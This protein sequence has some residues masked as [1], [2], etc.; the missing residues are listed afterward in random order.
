MSNVASVR[1]TQDQLIEMETLG[2]KT[3]SEYIKYKLGLVENNNLL[4]N[5]EDEQ[6]KSNLP[7]I[8][9]QSES[10]NIN[11]AV[12]IAR[13]ESERESLFKEIK[14]L[15]A[16][17]HETLGSIE[18]NVSRKLQDYKQE[19][20]RKALL[21]KTQDTETK[22]LKLQQEY[23][24]LKQK[25][26]K[27]KKKLESITSAKELVPTLQPLLGGL[28][29][30]IKASMEGGGLSG[31][32]EGLGELGNSEG[33]KLSEEDQKALSLGK[34]ITGM[35]TPEEFQKAMGVIAVMANDKSVIDL[36]PKVLQAIKNRQQQEN[37]TV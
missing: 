6:P 37:G 5:V 19:E 18:L 29:K 25:H 8:Y 24:E 12:K 27:N 28:A 7:I 31:F 4:G 22:M 14:E 9:N 16:Q 10:S 11:D 1:L 2:F 13:L 21:Q 33:T 36:I 3:P 20:E 35:F 30:G 15:R 17:Q 23:D 32:F 34:D 26:K